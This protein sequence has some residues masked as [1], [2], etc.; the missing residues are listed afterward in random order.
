MEGE[1]SLGG[2][3]QQVLVEPTV[4]NLQ[5]DEKSSKKEW[6]LRINE[7]ADGCQIFYTD[8]SKLEMGGVGGGWSAVPLAGKIEGYRG[9]GK[10]ATVW[11]REIAG[12]MEHWRQLDRRKGTEDLKR[13]V[14]EIG[15]RQE[16]STRRG[17]LDLDGYKSG[18]FGNEEA[19]ARQG[20]AAEVRGAVME[21]GEGDCGTKS[22][23]TLLKGSQFTT[24]II[25][26]L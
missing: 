2:R 1:L 5:L 8:G 20:A 7:A 12:V 11:H 25:Q 19:Q 23:K 15:E 3:C 14:N 9:L 16:R 17:G 18:M 22:E 4:V 21:W 6:G 13:V 10:V 24:T 26:D